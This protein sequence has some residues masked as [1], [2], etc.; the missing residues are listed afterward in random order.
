M[1]DKNDWEDLPVADDWEDMEVAGDAVGA[2]VGIKAG[3]TKGVSTY[4]GIPDWKLNFIQRAERF[5]TPPAHRGMEQFSPAAID[6]KKRAIATGINRFPF[7]GYLPNVVGAVKSGSVSSPEYIKERDSL[8]KYLDET[9][10]GTRL[11]GEGLSALASMAVP[12]GAAKEGAS[13]LGN[14]ARTVG[15]SAAIGAA[16][17]PGNVEGEITPL[18]MPDR[19]KGARDSALL[20]TLFAAPGTAVRFLR[21]RLAAKPAKDVQ[22]TIR[23]AKSLGISED[24]IPTEL[25]TS[26]TVV[27]DKAAALKRDPSLG[28]GMVRKKLQPFQDT[29]QNTAD[30]F[31]AAA[32]PAS[33]SGATVGSRV[34]TQI[35]EVAEGRLAPARQAY[36]ELA[37]PM[38]NA[39]PDTRAMKAGTTRLSRTVTPGD[40]EGNLRRVIEQEKQHFLDNIDDV[41]KLKAY[42]TELGRKSRDAYAK[43]DSR[44]GGVYDDLY[45]VMTRERDRSLEKGIRATGRK[46]GGE[47]QA[48]QGV[49]KLR[50]ADKLYRDEI[51][52]TMDA[53]GVEGRRSQPPMATVRESLES[54]PVDKLPD[55][56]WS[57]GDSEQAAK[58]TQAFPDQ[59]ED[60]RK[61][62]LQRVAKAAS[63]GPELSPTALNTQLDRMTPEAQKRLLADNAK[64]LPDYQRLIKTMP[65]P[66]FNPSQTNI[67]SETL[68]NWNPYKQAGSVAGA[69]ELNLRRPLEFVKNRESALM[70]SGRIPMAT[71]AI[72]SFAPDAVLPK[73]HGSKY[74]EPLRQ[75]A[76]R[77][78]NSFG[79]TYYLLS[80]SDP[81]FRAMMEREE[82]DDGTGSGY[83]G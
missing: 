25:L 64:A 44:L 46:I 37:E 32:H 62:Q 13:A 66:A 51:S 58:F 22:E 43:G 71:Q 65:D 45:D 53:L 74:E 5:I 3:S 34:R 41:E 60:I 80:Q 52:Q 68:H 10:G 54:T 61:L 9:E 21:E 1:A 17:N 19:L 70:R 73:V 26:D 75:A 83:G 40:T 79:A 30:D 4:E 24:E 6:Q 81:E 27:R 63:K 31:V 28:G 38:R 15:T 12:I 39:T 77:G 35:P 82:Q 36:D 67:R 23:I 16:Q 59:A 14:F 56:L 47:A 69:A 8:Q 76:Q 33:E 29:L 57:G 42:R 50:A 11:A 49:A 72:K 55:R 18:Q 20:A 78:D 2:D 48:K 7:F